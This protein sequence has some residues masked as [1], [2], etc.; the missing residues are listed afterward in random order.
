[1][2]NIKN[3]KTFITENLITESSSYIC[4]VCGDSRL[5]HEEFDDDPNDENKIFLFQ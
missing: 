4:K 2:K 5:E 3:F 1:M